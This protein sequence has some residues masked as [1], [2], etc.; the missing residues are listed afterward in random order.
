MWLHSLSVSVERN[1]KRGKYWSASRASM[2]RRD[3]SALFCTPVARCVSTSTSL[4]FA[5]YAILD[6]RFPKS[7]QAGRGWITHT[8]TLNCRKFS[9]NF[10]DDAREL[11]LCSRNN[12]AC[13]RKFDYRSSFASHIHVHLLSMYPWY[14]YMQICALHLTY[15]GCK[16]PSIR[17]RA[18]LCSNCKCHG[19]Y[20]DAK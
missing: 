2:Y 17:I 14:I 11:P 18:K 1:R 16:V 4:H 15:S 5:T 3:F 7:I 8:R 6:I 20:I 13:A 19:N 10:T 9:P 12:Y